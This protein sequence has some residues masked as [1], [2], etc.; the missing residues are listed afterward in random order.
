MSSYTLQ[1]PMRLF[2]AV[3][4][5]VMWIGIALTGFAVVSWILYIPAVFFLFA[6]LTGICPGIIISQK[7]LEGGKR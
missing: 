5:I 6:A 7:L 2:F 1:P 3:T 4:G